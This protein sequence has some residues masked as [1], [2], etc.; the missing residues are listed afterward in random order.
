VYKISANLR[1][2]EYWKFWSSLIKRVYLSRLMCT[3]REETNAK[4]KNIMEKVW[5]GYI[6]YYHLQQLPCIY[7]KG[8]LIFLFWS[9]MKNCRN[10]NEGAIFFNG[11]IYTYFK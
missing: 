5:G 2:D 11:Y 6:S 9:F 8:R 1:D 4:P 3:L 7:E 10:I